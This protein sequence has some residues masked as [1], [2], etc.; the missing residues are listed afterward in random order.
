MTTAGAQKEYKDENM[1]EVAMEN[2]FLV[3]NIDAIQN[4]MIGSF[5]DDPCLSLSEGLEK[6]VLGTHRQTI[7]PL[8]T[9]FKLNSIFNL[10]TA[11][12]IAVTDILQNEFR[13]T[14]IYLLQSTTVIILFKSSAKPQNDYLSFLHITFIQLLIE[15]KERFETYMVSFL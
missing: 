4:L 6:V 10:D 1:D 5:T 15:P 7:L 12:D 2:D 13:F 8:L 14:T 3:E 9:F 11:L